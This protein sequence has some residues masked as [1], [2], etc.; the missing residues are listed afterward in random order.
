MNL[1][2]RERASGSRLSLPGASCPNVSIHQGHDRLLELRRIPADPI[3][4]VSRPNRDLIGFDVD[5]M[6]APGDLLGTARVSADPA[7]NRLDLLFVDHHPPRSAA[8]RSSGEDD[9]N[10]PALTE[11]VPCPGDSVGHRRIYLGAVAL[12]HVDECAQVLDRQRFGVGDYLLAFGCRWVSRI[13]LKLED[14]TAGRQL[15]YAKRRRQLVQRR[16]M[17]AAFRSLE[18]LLA[19]EITQG[20]AE[21]LDKGLEARQREATVGQLPLKM[22]RDDLVRHVSSGQV[23]NASH[24]R[25]C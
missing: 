10:S 6:Q 5:A 20:A 3:G 15:D 1:L 22:K 11:R 17:S 21:V 24:R 8:G 19:V 13:W 7:S 9:A 2:D 16:G 18:P 23:A 4:A 14:C 25:D 12:N